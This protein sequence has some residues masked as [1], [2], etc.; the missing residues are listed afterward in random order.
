[1]NVTTPE[2]VKKRP[3][4]SGREIG[5]L[6]SMFPT[7]GLTSTFNHNGVPILLPFFLLSGRF[8]DC[9]DVIKLITIKIN[10]CNRK[11]LF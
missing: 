3:K 7:K 6:P 8:L 10:E 2:D 5:S 9:R 1:M 4:I 11:L